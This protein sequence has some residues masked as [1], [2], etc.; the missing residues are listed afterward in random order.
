MASAQKTVTYPDPP[1][2]APPAYAPPGGVGEAEDVKEPGVVKAAQA[3]PNSNVTLDTLLQGYDMYMLFDKSGSMS[4]PVSKARFNVTRWQD[5][6]EAA[7][8]MSTAVDAIDPDGAT[9][10]FFSDGIYVYN[11]QKSAQVEALFK[12]LKPGGLTNLYEALEY[13]F[14]DI[15][16]HVAENPDYKALIPIVTDG[17]PDLGH[18]DVETDKTNVAKLIVWFTHEMVKLG[19]TD[20]QVGISMIQVGN[21]PKASAYLKLLDDDLTKPVEEG[22]YGAAFDIVDTIPF[23]DVEAAGGIV[24]AF[25]RAFND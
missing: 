14:R 15:L 2:G 5:L 24:Q 18:D 4:G 6:R 22:G 25:V 3:A 19:M 8:S 12:G 20:D 10:I 16:R 17:I 13:T 23:A 7:V 21:D 9:V 1:K 11:N